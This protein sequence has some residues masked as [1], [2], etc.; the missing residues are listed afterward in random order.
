MESSNRNSTLSRQFDLAA[1]GRQLQGPHVDPADA[2]ARGVD[3]TQVRHIRAGFADVR[4]DAHPLGH[5]H[6]PPFDVH[7]TSAGPQRRPAFDDGGTESVPRQP[8]RQRR[9]G[10]AGSGDQHCPV[11]HDALLS[12]R[13]CAYRSAACIDTT[14][15]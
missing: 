15:I 6:G 9:P 11:A 1:A 14:A 5:V 2:P 3:E 4:H 12:S 10:D 7:R 8:V 13:R